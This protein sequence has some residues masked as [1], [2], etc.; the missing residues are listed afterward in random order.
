MLYGKPLS[1]RNKILGCVHILRPL[2]REALRSP[3]KSSEVVYVKKCTGTYS[4]GHSHVT[5]IERWFY[6]RVACFNRFHCTCVTT[7]VCVFWG[8]CIKMHNSKDKE[9]TLWLIHTAAT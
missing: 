4:L 9:E 6:C 7:C 1:M 8:G 2:N 3:K 5:F